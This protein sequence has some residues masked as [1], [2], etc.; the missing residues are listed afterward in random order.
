MPN[1]STE[2]IDAILDDDNV[3][4]TEAI[5]DALNAMSDEELDVLKV[6]AAQSFFNTDEDDDVSEED[7]EY[8]EDSEESDFE[9]NDEE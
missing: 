9:Y 2:I 3:R 5:F 7:Y 1:L 8:D 6:N 4:A